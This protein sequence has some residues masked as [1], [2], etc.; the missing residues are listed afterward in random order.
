MADEAKVPATLDAGTRAAPLPDAVGGGEL[1]A[2]TVG[3]VQTVAG[4]LPAVISGLRHALGEAGLLKGAA[5]LLDLNQT[6]GFD[7]PGCAWPDPE[8]RSVA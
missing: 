8:H 1:I 2:P 3:P 7:C 5:L 6:R 4:G